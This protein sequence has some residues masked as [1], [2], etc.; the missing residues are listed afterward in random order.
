VLLADDPVVRR[1]RRQRQ[2]R[3]RR[4]GGAAGDGVVAVA[5][6]Q[7]SST[8]GRDTELLTVLFGR[9]LEHGL[10]VRCSGSEAR[11][12][13]ATGM[14]SRNR[15]SKPMYRN[16]AMSPPTSVVALRLSRATGAFGVPKLT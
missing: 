9:D 4:E 6:S 5:G 13:A 2:G 3:R 11:M 1:F 12:P 7:V 16:C 15:W 8:P 10:A 14:N